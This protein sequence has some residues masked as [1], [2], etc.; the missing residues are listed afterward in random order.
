MAASRQDAWSREEDLVLAE[1]VLR[2]IREGSTQLSAFAEVGE[3]LSRTAAACGFR[4]NSLVRK[5]YGSAISLAKKQ[6]K[7]LKQMTPAV[8]GSEETV[9]SSISLEDVIAYL[10]RFRSEED[11]E[12][13]MK[14]N[15]ILKAEIA[16]LKEENAKLSRDV[17]EMKKENYAIQED[18]K[19]LIEIMDRARQRAVSENGAVESPEVNE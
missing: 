18:Y 14:E 13:M 8:N 15:E 2:H 4:W 7:Q 1:V 12:T 10:E 19:A 3:R 11:R 17:G 9:A 6:R 16:T 5:R